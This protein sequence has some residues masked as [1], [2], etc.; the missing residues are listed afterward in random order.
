MI[1]NDADNE[2]RVN[3]ARQKLFLRIHQLLMAM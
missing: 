1:L 2:A 3:A